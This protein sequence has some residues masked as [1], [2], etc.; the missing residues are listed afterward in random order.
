MNTVTSKVRLNMPKI[1]QL[2][3]ATT[4]ALEKTVNALQTEVIQAQVM[5]FGQGKRETYKE[6]GKRGQFAKNGREY[7]GK[8]KTRIIAPGGTLQNDS[9][10][11]DY[12]KSKQGQVKLISS[13]PYARRMYFHPEYNFYKGENKH[14]GGKWLEP[15][16]NGKKKKFCAKA[17][18]EFYKKESGL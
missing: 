6:Y 4:V 2:N 17:F 15:W 16:I 7:K 1:K 10:F 14:A 3:K 9:T 13:T 18:T 5:P 8:T 11:C 12:S